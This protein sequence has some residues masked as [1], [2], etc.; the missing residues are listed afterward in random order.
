[1][2]VRVGKQTVSSTSDAAEAL[3]KV[4]A[5]GTALVWVLRDGRELFVTMTKE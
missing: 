4:A 3:Q 5:R 1:M 2:I